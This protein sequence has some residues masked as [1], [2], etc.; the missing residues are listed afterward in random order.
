MITGVRLPL[1]LLQPVGCRNPQSIQLQF[2]DNLYIKPGKAPP[3]PHSIAGE[4]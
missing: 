3:D 4:I 1:S 2:A